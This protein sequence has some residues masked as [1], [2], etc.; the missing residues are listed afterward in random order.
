MSVALWLLSDFHPRSERC[1]VI[2]PGSKVTKRAALL[3]TFSISFFR[4]SMCVSQITLVYSS[5]GLMR[6]INAACFTC[7]LQ[8][9][10]FRLSNPRTLFYQV[11]M[12]ATF[13]LKLWVMVTPRYFISF[14]E[15]RARPE[16][17][18]GRG[19]SCGFSLRCR[20]F[21][22]WMA[23]TSC[24]ICEPK[25]LGFQCLVEEYCNPMVKELFG[26]KYNHWQIIGSL[27]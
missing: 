14:T 23:Q 19:C 10:R 13:H 16:D 7:W 22:T 18:I 5:I 12:S 9:D 2:V 6:P 20:L 8:N 11:T 27:I 21:Y 4:F 1:W 17:G 26:S 15:S 3:Y 24:S 25:T